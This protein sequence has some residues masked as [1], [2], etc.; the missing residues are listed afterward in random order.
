MSDHKLNS[1]FQLLIHPTTDEH[2]RENAFSRIMKLTKNKEVSIYYGSGTDA[3]LAQNAALKLELMV[4][5]KR[6]EDLEHAMKVTIDGFKSSSVIP[7]AKSENPIVPTMKTAIIESGTK[8]V[9]RS[10]LLSLF[11]KQFQPSC[12]QRIADFL[13]ADFMFVIP[14]G[15]KTAKYVHRS[16]RDEFPAEW[17]THVSRKEKV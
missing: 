16:H 10:D 3:V 13:N 5:T 17:A 12:A 8:G 14:S 6:L 7:V 2:T 9:L 15:S 11:D 1:A 4:I